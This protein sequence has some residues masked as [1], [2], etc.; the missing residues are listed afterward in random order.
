MQLKMYSRPLSSAGAP[1][2]SSSE[3]AS[4]AAAG[5]EDGTGRI[6]NVVVKKDR[7]SRSSCTL[8]ERDR[9]GRE[10]PGQPAVCE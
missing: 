7:M 10:A 1:S 8:I 5:A 6:L 3:P 9:E 4:D 2:S